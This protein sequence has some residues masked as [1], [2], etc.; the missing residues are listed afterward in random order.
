MHSFFGNKVFDEIGYEDIVDFI[1]QRIPEN[2]FLDY[3]GDI[4][5]SGSLPKAKEFGKDVSAFANTSGGWIIYGIATDEK[6][7]I[8]PLEKD[9]IVGL[10]DKSVLKESIEN[11][12]LSSIDPKPFY[13]IKKI[14]MPDNNRCLILVYIP[15][16]YRYIHM[17]AGKGENRFYKR[18]EYSSV[19]MDYYEVKK[20]FEE[21]GQTEEYRNNLIEKLVKQVSKNIYG[22]SKN[23]LFCLV[24]VPK[25]LL[26]GNFN[27]K[28]IIKK[29]VE[30]NRHKSFI[31]YDSAL[32]R[33]S[34]RFFS[35]LLPNE[36][37]RVAAIN[38]FYNGIIIQIV[39]IN[40]E[41]NDKLNALEIYYGI[42]NFI[43]LIF[44]FY[45]MFDFHGI[46]DLRFELKG[47]TGKELEFVSRQEPHFLNKD[48]KFDEE[49]EDQIITIDIADLAIQKVEIA[50]TLILPLFYNIGM[51]T[52]K[53]I[54]EEDGKP[55]YEV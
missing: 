31:K 54:C 51:D 49:I 35:E 18:Y 3:K 20:R 36:N 7:E 26:E 11:K 24:S 10:E 21:I 34:N 13:R 41:H 50:K 48:F 37:K 25:Y 27:N 30:K 6:D 42:Y 1:K 46:I 28:G 14:E 2:L 19:P 52:I 43:D 38:Y 15:Q 16:S 33:R 40:F 29:L 47:I 22:V 53:G 23:S 17:T 44:D 9:A 4:L 5:R 8:K 55:L 45:K 12:I 39:P 32:Q